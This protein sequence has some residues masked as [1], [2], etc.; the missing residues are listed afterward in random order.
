MKQNMREGFLPYWGRR[1]QKQTKLPD[2]VIN[3]TDESKLQQE[4][5]RALVARLHSEIA[6]LRNDTVQLNSSLGECINKIKDLVEKNEV[7]KVNLKRV[8]DAN[9]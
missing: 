1:T 8:D 7:L 2:P 6:V 4:Q 9:I 3:F 5:L